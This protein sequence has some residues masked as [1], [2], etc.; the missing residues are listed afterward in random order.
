MLLPRPQ[1]VELERKISEVVHLRLV[2]WGREGL[3]NCDLGFGVAGTWKAVGGDSFGPLA[4]Q[5]EEGFAVF[6]TRSTT[7]DTEELLLFDGTAAGTIEVD[8]NTTSGSFPEHF[9]RAGNRIYFTANYKTA[10]KD[11]GRELMVTD[12]TVAGTKIVADFI[13]GANAS[14]PRNTAFTKL[15]GM[16]TLLFFATIDANGNEPYKME[17]P[18]VTPTREQQATQ[19]LFT[20]FP[21]PTQGQFHVITSTD[22]T[23]GLLQIVD[24]QGRIVYQ[25]G[26]TNNGITIN[27]HLDKGVYFVKLTNNEQQYQVRK[28]VVME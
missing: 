8:L 22:I 7:D 18:L 17:I 12:G 28:L 19:D 3:P 21:N 5:L 9:C 27:K 13:D 15:N 14:N 25:E 2:F 20:L 4:L 16:P 24:I 26:V 1:I 11:Y 6:V 23:G 10:A